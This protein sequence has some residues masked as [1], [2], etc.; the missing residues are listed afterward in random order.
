MASRLNVFVKY[1]EETSPYVET[2]EKAIRHWEEVLK[3]K[4]GN[5][6][7]WN[8]SISDGLDFLT[9]QTN[10][11]ILVNL[12]NENRGDCPGWSGG[13]AH[14]N[15]LSRLFNGHLTIYVYTGSGSRDLI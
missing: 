6:G 13:C 12:E 7:A 14:N 15:W 3:E 2:V 5:Y 11:N 4:S 9:S 1:D 10:V 8:I